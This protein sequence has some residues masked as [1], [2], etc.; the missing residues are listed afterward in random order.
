[1]DIDRKK[2]TLVTS[3]VLVIGLLMILL[4]AVVYFGLIR[5]VFD[6]GRQIG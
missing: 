4:W 1:M 5:S 2:W 6:T 3:G